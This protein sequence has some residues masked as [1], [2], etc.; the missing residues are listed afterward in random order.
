M[1][2]YRNSNFKKKIESK[3]SWVEREEDG[4]GE[5]EKEVKE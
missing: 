3:V 4:E 1:K 2:N 5:R